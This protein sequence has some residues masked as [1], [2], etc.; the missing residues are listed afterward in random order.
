MWGQVIHHFQQQ[1]DGTVYRSPKEREGGRDGDAKNEPRG[2]EREQGTCS[3]IIFSISTNTAR[4]MNGAA[5]PPWR[6]PSWLV[7]DNRKL[8]MC[9]A[10]VPKVGSRAETCDLGEPENFT[11]EEHLS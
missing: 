4:G 9:G 3:R 1:K 11:K 6:N 10:D 8:T 2:G 7:A 5:A